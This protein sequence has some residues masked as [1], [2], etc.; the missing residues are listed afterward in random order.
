MNYNMIYNKRFPAQ[1]DPEQGGQGV[2]GGFDNAALQQVLG[3]MGGMGGSGDG[4]GKM[5]AA[6]INAGGGGGLNALKALLSG[7]LMV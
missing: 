2:Q 7:G 1:Q 4:E 5:M 3:G 6:K